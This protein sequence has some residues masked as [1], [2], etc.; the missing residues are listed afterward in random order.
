L[1][2]LSTA[3]IYLREPIHPGVRAIIAPTLLL[4]RGVVDYEFVPAESLI[5]VRF[6]R[7][8]TGVAE[9]VRMIEDAGSA[10]TSVAQRSA[11]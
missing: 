3:V 8:K 5:T 10:V 7:H 6:D 1:R 11:A 4:L 2:S 9:I